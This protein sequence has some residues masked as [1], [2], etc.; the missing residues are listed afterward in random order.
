MA[1]LWT[2]P[3]TS[4]RNPKNTWTEEDFE[5]EDSLCWSALFTSLRLILQRISSRKKKKK[6]KKKKTKNT[7]PKSNNNNARNKVFITLY[8]HG[9]FFISCARACCF[10]LLECAFDDDQKGEREREN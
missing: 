5:E 7:P 9:V 8:I 2:F 4:Y 10:S 3:F 1:K 6:K